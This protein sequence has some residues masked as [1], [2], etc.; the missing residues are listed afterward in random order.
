MSRRDFS[1]DK[2][3]FELTMKALTV[4]ALIVMLAPSLIVLVISFTDGMSLRFPPPGYSLRWYEALIDAW[5]LQ[6]AAKNSL[7]V[8]CLSTILSIV[9]GVAAALPIAR[10]VQLRAKVLDSIFMSPLV[11]PALSFGL[12]SLLFFSLAGVSA[13]ISTLVIGHAIVCVPYVVR[14]T[15]AS[16]VQLDP[17]LL[18]CSAS[19]GATRIYTLKRITLPLIKPGILAG[20]FIAFMSSF[21]NIP[22]S[23]FLRDASMEMLPI[24]MWQD[25]E[26]RLDVT[27]AALS[28]VLIIFTMV[29]MIIM[30]KF[31]GLSRRMA[32]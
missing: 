20:G 5:Q 9:F 31:V 21:D 2:L 15:V 17:A 7:L 22:I 23:L 13:S 25:L 30:E 14:N 12:A 6:F 16:L 10:S 8:A 19:L 24:R 29:M 4:I 1:A 32:S 18:E 28:G 27:I 11:L 3:S 26:N